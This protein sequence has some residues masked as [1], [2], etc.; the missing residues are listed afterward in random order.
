MQ[1]PIKIDRLRL[2]LSWTE[3]FDSLLD[4]KAS[5]APLAELGSAIALEA[6]FERARRGEQPHGLTMPWPTSET[7][8]STGGF[9]PYYL[10]VRG[11]PA[12]VTKGDARRAFVPLR[13]ARPPLALRPASTAG[14]MR[15]SQEA[16]VSPF[17]LSYV[18]TFDLGPNLSLDEVVEIARSLRYKQTLILVERSAERVVTLGKVVDAAFTALEARTLGPDAPRKGVR[19]PFTV[20][21][22]L[23]A[24]GRKPDLP[25]VEGGLE[26]RVLHA[27]ASWDAAWRD[28]KD[29][30]ALEA[31]CLPVRRGSQGRALYAEPRGRVTWFPVLF[32][33]THTQ[34]TV[35][36]VYHRSLVLAALQTERLLGLV[37][38]VADRLDHG[39]RLGVDLADYVRL[40]VG[41][42]GRLYAGDT[43]TY[44]TSSIEA[45]VDDDERGRA[46]ID[47]VRRELGMAPLAG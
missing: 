6:C 20:A 22:V 44:R 41:A 14:V 28:R 23:T 5:H 34:R 40:A 21:T 31:R 27:L 16:F 43:R 32:R 37:E 3:V 1:S 46:S 47:R 10:H 15:V 8:G 13:W 36:S 35:L 17:S 2:S 25:L 45:H 19:E 39:V 42:L 24:R 30:P 29:L 12:A 7:S 33:P 4:Q 11:D 18:L 38:L 9:W 26:H